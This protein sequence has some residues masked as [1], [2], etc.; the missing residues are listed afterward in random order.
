MAEKHNAEIGLCIRKRARA[1][2]VSAAPSENSVEVEENERR[3]NEEKKE[4]QRHKLSE[5]LFARHAV[6]F[7]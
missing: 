2:A 5:Q 6:P 4:L 7:S 3:K 1:Y